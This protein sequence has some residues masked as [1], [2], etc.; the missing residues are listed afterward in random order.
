MKVKHIKE[1][2]GI[3]AGCAT[4]I[5][6]LV[7]IGI[8]P[9]WSPSSSVP[10]TPTSALS[11]SSP[12]PTL[13]LTPTIPS[14]PK[15]ILT[16][17]TSRQPIINDQLQSQDDNTWSEN[18][19]DLWR[20]CQFSGGTY[21]SIVL[22]SNSYAPCLALAAQDENLQNIALQVQVTII[23]GDAGGLIFHSNA[24]GSNDYSFT[25]CINAACGGQGY[26]R[27]YLIQG[28][29][30]NYLTSG[31]STAIKANLNQNNLLTAV[32]YNGA[33][34]LYVNDEYVAHI[35]DNTVNAGYIGLTAYEGINSTDVSFSNIQVWKL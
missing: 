23:Q 26:Y 7:A 16:W 19:T 34:Y 24:S 15:D 12:T 11:N 35:N 31:P 25:I 1:I 27:L 10:P 13:N 9:R 2:I 20:R 32:A 17:A 28:A 29:H 14:N 4:I 22:H 5:G 33:I 30:A 21:H 8:I 18:T 6:L 3:L